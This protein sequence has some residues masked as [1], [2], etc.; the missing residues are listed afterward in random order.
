MID[1]ELGKELYDQWGS[2]MVSKLRA[3]DQ[4]ACEWQA[5]FRDIHL[6]SAEKAMKRMHE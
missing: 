1:E 3:Y 6:L 4:H 5:F 2:G